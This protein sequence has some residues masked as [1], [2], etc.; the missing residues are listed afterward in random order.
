MMVRHAG[1]EGFGKD[2]LTSQAA[3]S[4]YEEALICAAM[5]VWVGGPLLLTFS[6]L[7]IL[8][9]GPMTNRLV[10]VVA[11]LILAMHP[12][13]V[14]REWK[15]KLYQGWL[16]R[17]LY[18]YFSYRF[19]WCDDDIAANQAVAQSGAWIG[20]GPPHG[21][22]PL[23][24]V[25][26]I[27]AINSFGFCHFVGA[28]ASVVFHTPFLRY[29]ALYDCV[30][31]GRKSLTKALAQGK[32]VGI[33]PDGVAG[34][35]TQNSR[36][37][38]VAM[39]SKKGIARLALRTGASVV[40]AYSF[41]NTAAFTCVQDQFGILAKVSRKLRAALFIFHGRWWLPIPRRVNITMVVGRAIPVEKVEEPSEAQV[42]ELHEKIL[43]AIKEN[44]DRHKESLGWGQKELR[45]I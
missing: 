10:F 6:G 16:T 20:A 3:I 41:G 25:L 42:D 34:I 9:L 23:A 31:V 29:L 2:A 17:S 5:F 13:P 22:L 30:S 21:V 4:P 15:L 33:V 26:S 12:L 19:V 35:F 44:F 36:D 28:P 39:R 1:P 27:P 8:L 11:T 14:S 37:E 7:A 24:N 40:P 45:F 38:V 43:G 32:C 18:K